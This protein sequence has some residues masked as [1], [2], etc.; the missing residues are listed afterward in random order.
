MDVKKTK[1][2][3]FKLAL[4]I[5]SML[6][7][8][9]SGIYSASSLS[10]QSRSSKGKTEESS[11]SKSSDKNK[12]ASN[13]KTKGK[14]QSNAKGK[15]QASSKGKSQASAKGQAKKGAPEEVSLLIGLGDSLGIGSAAQVYFQVGP[16]LPA[17]VVGE[18]GKTG[19]GFLAG[20]DLP[21][22]LPIELPIKLHTGAS[23]GMYSVNMEADLNGT[24]QTGKI[25]LLPILLYAKATL[26]LPGIPLTPYG[27]LGFG[28]TSVATTVDNNSAFNA[29][30]FDGTMG[31]GA[32]AT[33]VM[34]F[35]PEL[36][37]NVGFQYL[38]VFEKPDNGSF[39]NILFGVSY[40]L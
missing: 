9:F 21:I 23:V 7:Y 39:I 18:V 13:E 26:D 20:G 35:M 5:G 6:L 24:L 29:S 25:R 30:S 33:Y 22:V 10:A 12:K 11:K 32:G 4:A 37:A 27:Y 28:G 1:L 40:K 38:M 16:A 15:Q 31:L 14:N 34:P 8:L 19:F 36:S 17:G 2:H 3:S